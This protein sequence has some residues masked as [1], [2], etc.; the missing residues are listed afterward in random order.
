MSSPLET[1]HAP[2]YRP[3]FPRA[4]ATQ[5]NPAHTAHGLTLSAAPGISDAAQ[6]GGPAYLQVVNELHGEITLDVGAPS[7][8]PELR[9]IPRANVPRAAALLAR[10]EAALRALPVERPPARD[11]YQ[12]DI[13]IQFQK[14]DE[15]VW[16]NVPVAVGSGSGSGGDGGAGGGIE[17][18]KEQKAQFLK[19]L[20]DVVT[21]IAI[22]SDRGITMIGNE[23]NEQENT[24][25]GKA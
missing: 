23:G 21:L 1:A 2:S 19:V 10:I 13:G 12:L 22:S 14:G 25:R 4:L 9:L 6:Q 11:I 3:R 5:T 17:P 15:R 16:D 24:G 20:G 18:T 7:E 8:P